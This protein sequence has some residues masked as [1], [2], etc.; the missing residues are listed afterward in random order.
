MNK[1]K[2]V[3]IVDDESVVRQ[4]LKA[5]VEE[6]GYSVIAEGTSGLDAIDICATGTVD[7][8]IMDIDM[9]SMDGLE[10]AR[11][12]RSDSPTPILLVTGCYEHDAIRDAIDA[13][14]S[15]YL[16]KPVRLEDLEPAIEF[17]FSH[18][19]ECRE[20]REQVDE[21]KGTLA[22]RPVIE[23]A[24]GLLMEHNGIGEAEA[25]GRIRK[26]SMDKRLRMVEVAEAIILTLEK[27]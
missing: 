23:K 4:V 16:V 26:M 24:K 19:E 3:A 14:V 1:K 12:I 6:C 27:V 11:R 13:G 22:S 18:S 15:T 20:L 21:L 8:L 2:R 9:P 10:A 5:M 25:F 7:L 17:A